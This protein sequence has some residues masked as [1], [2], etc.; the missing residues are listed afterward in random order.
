MLRVAGR[1]LRSEYSGCSS[2]LMLI[3]QYF[4]IVVVVSLVLNLAI[5]WFLLKQ[6]SLVVGF[7]GNTR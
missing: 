3:E 4:V 5:Q 7:L 2:G 6:A 1:I